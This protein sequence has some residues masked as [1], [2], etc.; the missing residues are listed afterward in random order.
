MKL[1]TYGTIIVP[2]ITRSIGLR[3]TPEASVFIRG[4]R[5]VLQKETPTNPKFPNYHL[6]KLVH[7]NNQEDIIPGF[8]I[9]VAQPEL[10][11]L[12]KW[13]GTTYKRS[14]VIA[15]DR[16]LDETTCDVCVEK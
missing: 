1:F 5:L 10:E 15:Y 2:E 9:E 11:S 13:E 3:F 16:N 7:T 14:T 6:M 12:D 8:L 4:Y